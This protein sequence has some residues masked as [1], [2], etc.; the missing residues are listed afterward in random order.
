MEGLG[1]GGRHAADAGALGWID[2]WVNGRCLHT[3]L[4]NPT[5]PNPNPTQEAMVVGTTCTVIL[6]TQPNSKPY[7]IAQTMPVT[8]NK[9]I[10]GHPIDIPVVKVAKGVAR[11]FDGGLDETRLD[12]QEG[13]RVVQS[14]HI[15]SRIRHERRLIASRTPQPPH[16]HT[17]CI[18]AAT[19]T[20]AS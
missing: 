6:L 7:T 11:M 19:W 9:I 18:P 2:G 10:I 1:L 13:G 3:L 15:H 20:C 16:H 12:G 8:T 17:Q 14:R 4:T 5:Q